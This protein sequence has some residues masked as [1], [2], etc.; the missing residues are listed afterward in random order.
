MCPGNPPH[1]RPGGVAAGRPPRSRLPPG[2]CHTEPSGEWMLMRPRL[3][4]PFQ[5]EITAAPEPAEAKRES[6]FSRSPPGGRA[7]RHKV[8]PR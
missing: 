3:P 6:S 5:A 1:P 7:E 2:L 4:K 8:A